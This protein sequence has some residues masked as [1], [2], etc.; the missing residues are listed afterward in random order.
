[1]ILICEDRINCLDDHGLMIV[2]SGETNPI[3]WMLGS[4]FNST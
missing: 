4:G 1:M 2:K 3:P